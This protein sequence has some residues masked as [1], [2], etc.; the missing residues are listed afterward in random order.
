MILILYQ[1]STPKF[2]APAVRVKV[3]VK[4]GMS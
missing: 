1:L 4:D 2:K 3:P